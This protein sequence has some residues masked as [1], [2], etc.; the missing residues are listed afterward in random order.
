MPAGSFIG[1]LVQAS[2]ERISK[3]DAIKVLDTTGSTIGTATNATLSGDHVGNVT[4]AAGAP[5]ALFADTQATA[6]N[7]AFV[8]LHHTAAITRFRVNLWKPTSR[9]EGDLE[10]VATYAL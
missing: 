1:V 8:F 6:T 4:N 9:S 7:K 10:W 3:I 2:D 5:N